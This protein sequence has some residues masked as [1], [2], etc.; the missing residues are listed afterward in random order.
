MKE[1]APWPKASLESDSALIIQAIR[2]QVRMASSFGIIVKD[3]RSL[4]SQL[5]RLA[6]LF[7]YRSA[8]KCAHSYARASCSYPERI[9]TC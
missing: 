6:L 2:S 7:I 1:K 8:N 5:K 3:Y 9:F 4:C